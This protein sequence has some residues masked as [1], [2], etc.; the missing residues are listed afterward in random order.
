MV[1]APLS[2][3]NAAFVALNEMRELAEVTEALLDSGYTRTPR[4]W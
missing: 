1:W 2:E 3:G 4:D